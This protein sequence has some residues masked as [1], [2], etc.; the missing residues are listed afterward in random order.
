MKAISRPCI[1]QLL[2][3]G[4]NY[5]LCLIVAAPGSG[6]STA[7]D[8]WVGCRKKQF[9][10]KEKVIR[11]DAAHKFN[12]GDNLFLE[13]FRRLNT[14]TPLWEASFFKLFKSDQEADLDTLID[15]FIQGFSQI[16]DT[17]C[18]II[19]D[20]HLIKSLRVM[21]IFN[22]LISQLPSHITLVISSRTYPNLSISKFKLN[23]SVLI[24]DGNDLKLNQ[25]ELADLNHLLCDSQINEDQLNILLQQTE[26]WLVGIKLAL[27][28]YRKD[29]E[30]ALEGF[31]GTQPEL[32][33]YFAHEVINTLPKGIKDCVLSISICS[34]F[35]QSLYNAV[36]SDLSSRIKL[37]E[38][39]QQELLIT[40]ELETAHWYRFHPLLQSFLL[41]QLE[42][43]KGAKHIQSL[44]LKAA[45]CL[46]SLNKT[47]Q[48][49]E[50]AKQAG[51]TAFYVDTLI[52]ATTAWLKQGE[53]E[54]I[55][56]ALNQLN[57]SEL[58]AYPA[59]HIYL[60][61]ALTF[62][63]RFNQASF[64]LEK[65]QQQDRTQSEIETMRF[66]KFL[67]NLFQSDS[68]IQNLNLPKN[69]ISSHTP[70]DVIGFYL[71]LEAY[72]HLYNGELNDAFK[73]ATKAQQCL[74]TIRHDFFLS[75]SNLIIILCDRYLGRGLEAIQL[76]LRTFSPLKN[77]PKNPVWVN[78]AS[79]MIVVEYEQN[80]LTEALELGEQLIPLVSH[81]SVTEVII[82]AYF[83]SARI[84]HI[85]GNKSKA[86]RLLNQLERILSL[87]DYE[88]FN[89]QIVH[90]KMRQAIT[91]SSGDATDILLDRYHLS[92]YSSKDVWCRSGRY[93]EHRERLALARVYAYVA[94]GQFE[95]AKEILS[96]VV[97]M[98]DKQHLPSRA[99]IARANLA[100]IAYKQHHKDDALRQLKR[101]IDQYGLVFFSRT[102]F[103]EAPGLEKLFQFAEAQQAIKVPA[104]FY[105]IFASLFET[106]A[107]PK[108]LIQPTH[109][110]TEKELAIFEL[111]SEGLSNAEIS[112]QSHIALSTTK[113]H[114]QNIYSKLGVE[115]RSAALMLAH[116]I[117]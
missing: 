28:A 82:N 104:I 88:R 26:G 54:P 29:G 30:K 56:D 44:H 24:I 11:F 101:L 35:N 73:L 74:K 41:Q 99:L 58:K 109:R 75:Y 43:E 87:G 85:F 76:M 20:F 72:N 18:I 92:T 2:D 32:L 5:P 79:G 52:K 19:D 71:I 107:K 42:R 13:I 10:E 84:S 40:P 1:H 113:W 51:N 16:T 115:N 4:L 50:H 89:S 38:L 114:L 21:A 22:N 83:Y 23:E 14:M 69:R 62:S 103:D 47:S 111:L 31:S 67:I 78:I 116:K 34:S 90:E 12:E 112:K 37:E 100:M 108:A 49:I 25:D 45:K 55:I 59:L 80:R 27:L 17:I 110:L 6:K 36:N 9:G 68:E 86:K 7:I 98:L 105:R 117:N 57:D 39:I 93:E 53:F 15:I 64:Q 97:H 3:K 63:R 96:N 70:R 33:N 46:L 77:G 95:Q 91:E 61:Y 94:K 8:Q 81:S 65:L 66:L 102:V 106:S 48:A 60:I